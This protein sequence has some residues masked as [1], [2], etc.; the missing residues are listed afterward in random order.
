MPFSD[1]SIEILGFR[2]G[3]GCGSLIALISGVS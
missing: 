2:A 1:G 3:V